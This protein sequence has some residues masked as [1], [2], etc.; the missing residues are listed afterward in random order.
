VDGDEPLLITQ[1][2]PV[3]RRGGG[4]ALE[5][6]DW[7]STAWNGRRPRSEEG[8]GESAF[9]RVEGL[10]VTWAFNKV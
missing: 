1:R 7:P 8:V 2:Q 5:V 4:G 9:F 10:S 6:P 3:D